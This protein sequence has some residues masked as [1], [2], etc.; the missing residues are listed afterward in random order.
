MAEEETGREP[1]H[2]S[3]PPPRGG[4]QT[5]NDP[6]QERIGRAEGAR[7]RETLT[8]D[9]APDFRRAARNNAPG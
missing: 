9:W 5:P 6:D 4:F 2:N 3:T 1:D 8:Q 7:R